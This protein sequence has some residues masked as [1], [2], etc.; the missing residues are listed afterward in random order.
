[1]S[2]FGRAAGLPDN[3]HTS[4][5]GPTQGVQIPY[6]DSYNAGSSFCCEAFAAIV[7]LGRRK[8]SS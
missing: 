5:S 3:V 1:M 8:P 4:V 2:P 7:H 6:N